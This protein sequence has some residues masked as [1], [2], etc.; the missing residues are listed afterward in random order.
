MKPVAYVSKNGVLFKDLPPEGMDLMP[1]YTKLDED[2]EDWKPLLRHI[3]ENKLLKE[4][5]EQL[6]SQIK[7]LEAQ[8]YGGTTK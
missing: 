5:N 4:E 2:F 1:L 6:K 8:V 3:M 7:H